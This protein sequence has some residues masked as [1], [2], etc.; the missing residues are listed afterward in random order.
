MEGGGKAPVATYLQVK[1][2][3][4]IGTP[5]GVVKRVLVCNQPEALEGVVWV[6]IIPLASFAA[7]VTLAAVKALGDTLKEKSVSEPVLP[8]I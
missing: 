1:K 7:A 5:Y 8:M 2:L 4:L 3:G 6:I